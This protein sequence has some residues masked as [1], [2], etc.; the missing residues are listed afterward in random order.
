M[1]RSFHVHAFNGHE[2]YFEDNLVWISDFLGMY[3]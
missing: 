3:P 2:N 1:H